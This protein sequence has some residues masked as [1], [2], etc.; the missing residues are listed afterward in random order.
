MIFI[1]KDKLPTSRVYLYV[2]LAVLALL[3]L[4]I[5]APLLYNNYFIIDDFDW[6]F[7]GSHV[8]NRADLLAVNPGHFYDPLINVYF[9]LT[10]KLFA[11]N[12][13]L[14]YLSNIVLHSIN[15]WLIFVLLSKFIKWRYAFLLMLLFAFQY[16]GAEVLFLINSAVHALVTMW[17]LLSM[18]AIY[19]YSQKNSFWLLIVYVLT[20]LLALITKE[21]AYILPLLQLAWLF[22]LFKL[23]ITDKRGKK[24][25]L[26]V[27][28]PLVI[29]YFIFGI[30][31]YTVL[32]GGDNT[33][34]YVFNPDILIQLKTVLLS[35]VSVFF[36][37]PS[38]F[39]WVHILA[40]ILLLSLWFRAPNKKSRSLWLFGL[41]W[42]LV[43]LIYLSFPVPTLVASLDAITLIPRRY[44][45][46]VS[47]GMIF[48]LAGYFT[49]KAATICK[50]GTSII[51]S[52]LI[53]YNIVGI[54]HLDKDVYQSMSEISY[55][56]TNSVPAGLA[57][58]VDIIYILDGFPWDPSN[59]L[60]E[61]MDVFHGIDPDNIRYIYSDKRNGLEIDKDGPSYVVLVFDYDQNIWQV[62]EIAY[63]K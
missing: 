1:Q 23:K 3:L 57:D 53:I 6:L 27:F 46:V 33:L 7:F 42:T 4:I 8:D 58:K 44:G 35:A 28:W 52:A 25:V 29:I 10:Y 38:G 14:H 12:P 39:V 15:S 60:Y 13:Q 31:I 2:F 36:Y 54:H 40:A 47:V 16:F 59:Y 50:I 5:Y 17:I 26:K 20:T 11:L 63:N 56:I 22:L 24:R 51:L 62:A 43:Y 18:L 48:M 49:N 37:Q 32:S 61:M 19:Y 45:Y 41:L 9:W 55:G 34:G 21:I 30:F